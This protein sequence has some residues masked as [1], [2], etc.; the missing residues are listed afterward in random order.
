MPRIRHYMGAPIIIIMRPTGLIIRLLAKENTETSMT[1]DF[2][3]GLFQGLSTAKVRR[4]ALAPFSTASLYITVPCVVS[5]AFV[6]EPLQV[7]VF[8]LAAAPVALLS[9]GS[10]F[11]LF[12]DRERLHTEEYLER[13]HAMEIVESKSD[14]VMLEASDLV[15]MVNPDHSPKALPSSEEEKSNG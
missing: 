15:N 3:K 11:L 5:L 14:G 2:V 4:S 12:F 10:L 8:G 9:I 7:L 1:P 13:K 6:P